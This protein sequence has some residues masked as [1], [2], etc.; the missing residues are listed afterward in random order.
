MDAKSQ[1]VSEA[2]IA[3]MKAQA[4]QVKLDMLEDF[5]EKATKW[6]KIQFAAGATAMSLVIGV[7]AYVGFSGFNA[8]EEYQKLVA[9]SEKNI[10]DSRDESLQQMKTTQEVVQNAISKIEFDLQSK[11][12]EVDQ[13]IDLKLNQ[14]RQINTEKISQYESRLTETLNEVT[15]L[16]RAVKSNL[17]KSVEIGDNIEK[18]EN[19]RFRIIVHYRENK[20]DIYRNNLERLEAALFDRGF[21]IDQ[22]DIANVSTDRQEIIYYSNS[23]LVVT[24]MKEIQAQLK[25]LFNHIP[26]RH[27]DAASL[28]SLQVVIKLCPQQ[29]GQT[30]QCIIE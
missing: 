30:R 19:S 20:Q 12:D 7:L 1:R 18:L 17:Q 23:A 11:F 22:D 10:T 15:S 25:A 9:D 3:S 8:A 5:Q 2:F 24:K 14:L 27:E 6:V 28:D 4:Q 26:I 13:E 21:V 29:Q 16:Q